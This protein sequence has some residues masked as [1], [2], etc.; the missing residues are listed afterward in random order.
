MR[1][2]KDS[3]IPSHFLSLVYTTFVL[4]L[5]LVIVSSTMPTNVLV[6]GAAGVVGFGVCDAWLKEHDDVVVCAVARSE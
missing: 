6:L 4:A 3:I 2:P 1:D 5:C